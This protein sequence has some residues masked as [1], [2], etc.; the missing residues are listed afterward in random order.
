ML[1]IPYTI[2][3]KADMRAINYPSPMAN[4]S[5]LYNILRCCV[6]Y[7]VNAYVRSYYKVIK[8][9]TFSPFIESAEL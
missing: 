6:A 9:I 5:H 3:I 7:A 2:Q 8:M 1:S 4:L